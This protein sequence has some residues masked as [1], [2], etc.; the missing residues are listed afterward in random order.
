MIRHWMIPQFGPIGVSSCTLDA[1]G[2][3]CVATI[4]GMTREP[5]PEPAEDVPTFIVA[6]SYQQ[7]RGYLDSIPG[8]LRFPTDPDRRRAKY[9]LNS[10]WL[11]GVAKARF[12]IT[13]QYWRHPD[14]DEILR[15]IFVSVDY[16]GAEVISEPY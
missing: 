14:W 9:V 16:F 6:G 3:M 15:A 12:I 1:P 4:P 13:G 5:E 2:S 11:L 10:D 8:K 7:Y